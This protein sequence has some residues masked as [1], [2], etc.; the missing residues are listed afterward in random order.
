MPLLTL[1][2]IPT[3]KSKKLASKFLC[4]QKLATLFTACS[5]TY[6]DS[7][8]AKDRCNPLMDCSLVAGDGNST[9]VAG[10]ENG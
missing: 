6:L 2:I 1:K 8:V 10:D 9:V 4:F 7:L 3:T 5:P